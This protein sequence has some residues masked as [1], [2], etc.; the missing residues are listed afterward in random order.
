MIEK[1]ERWLWPG[2]KTSRRLAW[3]IPAVLYATNL[4][5]RLFRQNG[6]WDIRPLIDWLLLREWFVLFGMM[7]LVCIIS[8]LADSCF[9]KIIVHVSP[10]QRHNQGHV[11]DAN[12]F[13]RG[14]L[15]WIWPYLFVYGLALFLLFCIGDLARISRNSPIQ[16][17]NPEIGGDSKISEMFL[18]LDNSKSVVKKGPKYDEY[19]RTSTSV[20]DERQI[21]DSLVAGILELTLE[22]F[23]TL[24]SIKVILVDSELHY[25][26]F[27]REQ[28]KRHLKKAYGR[29]IN[30]MGNYSELHRVPRVVFQAT[31]T[32]YRLTPVVILS[33]GKVSVSPRNRRGKADSNTFQ[34]QFYEDLYWLNKM[35]NILLVY[36]YLRAWDQNIHEFAHHRKN[37]SEAMGSNL[38]LGDNLYDLTRGYKNYLDSISP[39]LASRSLPWRLWFSLAFVLVFVVYMFLYEIVSKR[40]NANFPLQLTWIPCLAEEKVL[41]RLMPNRESGTRIGVPKKI[42][43][44]NFELSM[45]PNQ[46]RL[47][48]LEFRRIGY[49]N[50]VLSVK[51]ILVRSASIHE[52]QPASMGP[53]DQELVLQIWALPSLF[54]VH[55][56]GGV[57]GAPQNYQIQKLLFV[58]P[59]SRIRSRRNENEYEYEYRIRFF[60]FNW[61]N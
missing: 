12:K 19:L 39:H 42:L 40:W 7:I 35:K 6:E 44:S 32:E 13:W 15:R 22:K 25:L 1:L 53:N 29:E 38:I 43:S 28:W 21:L 33:D 48:T 55:E 59:K 10:R 31:K 34:K 52:Q 20:I 27:Q 30:F 46:N 11:N 26:V 60:L 16:K 36:F 45:R 41:L 51:P 54:E 61:G 56:T 3:I 14:F 5:V 47:P 18:V 49:N 9:D 57:A 37:L 23:S 17:Y 58:W 50:N 2:E 4:L 24:D 8:L